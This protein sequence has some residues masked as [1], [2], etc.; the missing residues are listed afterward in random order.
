VL[1]MQPFDLAFYQQG[2][3]LE[4]TLFLE[5]NRRRLVEGL[6]IHSMFDNYETK[7]K[8]NKAAAKQKAKIH[9]DNEPGAKFA[10]YNNSS[11]GKNR[12]FR[13]YDKRKQD[14]QQD[15]VDIDAPKNKKPAVDI[16]E[17]KNKKPCKSPRKIRC[18]GCQHYFLLGPK[19]SVT[20]IKR[21]PTCRK[22]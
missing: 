2:P 11:K 3:M 14:T 18:T 4:P 7:A 1:I 22:K 10:K 6:E 21:C 12:N 16:D 8:R 5:A 9:A 20:R 19:D 15:A 13:H 17:T